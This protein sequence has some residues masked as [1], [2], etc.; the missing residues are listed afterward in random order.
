MYYCA[1]VVTISSFRRPNAQKILAK[2]NAFNVETHEECD[3]AR[4]FKRA[5]VS[6]Q[7]PS[8]LLEIHEGCDLFASL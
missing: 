1:I 3:R 7:T 8:K 6:E 5:K 4:L 2:T